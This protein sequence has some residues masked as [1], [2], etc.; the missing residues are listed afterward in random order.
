M[1]LG[2]GRENNEKENAG[3]IAQ[4]VKAQNTSCNQINITPNEAPILQY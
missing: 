2:N 4:I 1:I 3:M